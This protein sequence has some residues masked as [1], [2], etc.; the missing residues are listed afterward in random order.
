MVERME[1]EEQQPATLGTALPVGGA[2]PSGIATLQAQAS[3]GMFLPQDLDPSYAD[4][5]LTC[6]S[7]V[8]AWSRLPDES[9]NYL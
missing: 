9:H 6:G 2:T 1:R 5:S 7:A 3:L 4:A 8:E